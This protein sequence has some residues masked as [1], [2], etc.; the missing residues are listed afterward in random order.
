MLLPM[1]RRTAVQELPTLPVE[2]AFLDL[3]DAVSMPRIGMAVNMVQLRRGKSPE[4]S[5]FP[6]ITNRI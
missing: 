3:A 1:S 5:P 4:A 6:K 2:D